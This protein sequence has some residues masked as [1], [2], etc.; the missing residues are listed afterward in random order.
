MKTKKNMNRRHFLRNSAI[1]L[2]GTLGFYKLAN[3]GELENAKLSKLMH[4]RTQ[5]QPHRSHPKPHQKK[6]PVLRHRPRPVSDRGQKSEVRGQR[7][8]VSH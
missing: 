2:G 3:S 6:R 7:S 1:G 4:P 8:E 5:E